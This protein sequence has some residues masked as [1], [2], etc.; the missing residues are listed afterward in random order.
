[1]NLLRSETDGVRADTVV[2]DTYDAAY[3]EDVAI[4]KKQHENHP[5]I[6]RIPAA[7]WMVASRLVM[8][9]N[10]PKHWICMCVPFADDSPSP[11][12]VYD[13][14]FLRRAGMEV[15][16]N[17]DLY[18]KWCRY[19]RAFVFAM[20][21]YYKTSYTTNSSYVIHNG[22]HQ[23]DGYT[24]GIRAFFA[25]RYFCLERPMPLPSPGYGEG[26]FLKEAALIELERVI[27]GLP[28]VPRKERKEVA[29]ATIKNS[30]I[31][32][33][34]AARDP[35]DRSPQKSKP[36]TLEQA[37]PGSNLALDLSSC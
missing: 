17:N 22:P 16:P 9:I 18:E 1:M 27:E 28:F 4:G 8:I 29:K 2:M 14:I 3:I 33:R 37:A 35:G 26:R 5:T 6:T 12:Q 19:A 30:I 23:V 25:A 24:C 36:R 15:P 32:L 20:N 13:S 21:V 31:T 11:I 34:D 7:Q 10:L